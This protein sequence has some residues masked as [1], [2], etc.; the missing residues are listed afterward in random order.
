METGSFWRGTSFNNYY[1]FSFLNCYG[2]RRQTVESVI[3]DKDCSLIVVEDSDRTSG[4]WAVKYFRE[5]DTSN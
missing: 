4:A 2:Q 3:V 5:I 1:F